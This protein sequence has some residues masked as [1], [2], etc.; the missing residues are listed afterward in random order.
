MGA[1]RDDRCRRDDLSDANSG[2]RLARATT[3]ASGPSRPPA[4]PATAIRPRSR[5]RSRP[6]SAGDVVLYALKTPVRVGNWSP[7][8]DATAA[9]GQAACT[10]RTPA[11]PPS[12]HRL[13]NPAH[14]FEMSFGAQAGRRVSSMDPR[15][16]ARQL[17]VQRLVS[18]SSSTAV[19]IPGGTPQYRIGTTT[20]TY[21]NLAGDQRSPS[22][23]VGMAGQRIWCRRHRTGHL[24]RH[25]R[26]A[27]I[28]VQVREDG[29]R[30]IRSSCLPTPS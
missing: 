17:R 9:G 23:W 29:S 26:H 5:H 12:I 22:E 6:I 1:D 21:V 2:S 10:T 4:I 25:R 27:D 18:G 15:Q 30:S 8:A 19:W 14:Y 28:R 24:L 13:A 3:I 7:V 20:G 11:R 16:S